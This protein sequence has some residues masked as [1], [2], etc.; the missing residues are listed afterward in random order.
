MEDTQAF[1][2]LG[3]EQL[4]GTKQQ[5]DEG[6]VPSTPVASECNTNGAAAKLCWLLFV[7]G[8]LCPPIWWVVAVKGLKCS[9]RKGV[10]VRDLSMSKTDKVAWLACVFMTV[11]SAVTLIL[12]C[13]IHYGTRSH[14][15]VTTGSKFYYTISGP[16]NSFRT[17][18]HSEAANMLAKAVH[19]ALALPEAYPVANIKAEWVPLN[20][21]ND[22]HAPASHR[23]LLTAAAQPAS[24]AALQK[25][26]AT[27]DAV[28]RTAQKAAGVSTAVWVLEIPRTAALP[29]A[30]ELEKRMFAE[31]A[32]LD[33]A[34][35]L[36]LT[37]YVD[38]AS[39]TAVQ[40]AFT[41]DV[42]SAAGP[43]AGATGPTADTRAIYNTT[44]A[45]TSMMLTF[46][47]L[48]RSWFVCL[49]ACS[50]HDRMLTCCSITVA[51]MHEPHACAELHQGMW[52]SDMLQD[53]SLPARSFHTLQPP[54]H[55][56]HAPV[57]KA[58]TRRGCPWN[59][60]RRGQ[61]L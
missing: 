34:F 56:A 22:A 6:V 4:N 49:K 51:S 54:C 27:S 11:A 58:T 32:A 18:S 41:R 52:E 43:F 50:R 12:G 2:I 21:D 13:A 46:T 55:L 14:G 44:G 9:S 15:S 8:F 23:H 5:R 40:A 42:P 17:S 53:N 36:V 20:A 37:G 60:L 7:L 47:F 26:S 16:A 59:A 45:E 48:T 57:D 35:Q 3:S 33:L 38:A 28:T 25:P 29:A 10:Q 24:S 19:K 30:A 1:V 61:V 39:I 31:Y